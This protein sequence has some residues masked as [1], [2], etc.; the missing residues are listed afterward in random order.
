M[1]GKGERIREQTERWR[2]SVKAGEIKKYKE[3]WGGIK[4]R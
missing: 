2:Q 1:V 4:G 3:V